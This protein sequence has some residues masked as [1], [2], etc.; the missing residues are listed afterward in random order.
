MLLWMISYKAVVFIRSCFSVLLCRCLGS[1]ESRT[2]LQVWM[3]VWRPRS[4]KYFLAPNMGLDLFNFDAQHGPN[5]F[6]TRVK[7]F[8]LIVRSTYVFIYLLFILYVI[9][10]STEL[11][12][13]IAIHMSL[14]LK[15]RM[16][17]PVYT[18]YLKALDILLNILTL[19]KRLDHCNHSSVLPSQFVRE[20]RRFNCSGLCNGDLY[21]LF[22][23]IIDALNGFDAGLKIFNEMCL[24]K[25]SKI[26]R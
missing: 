7:C 12:K 9:V 14:L 1:F 24:K 16:W 13:W 22:E 6:L 25:L 21:K 23:P 2:S 17:N 5:V 11:E 19:S 8:R 3:L 26:Q 4:A 10:N 20:L 15:N 18:W